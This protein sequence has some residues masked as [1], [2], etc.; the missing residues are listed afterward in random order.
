MW[1]MKIGE[2]VSMKSQQATTKKHLKHF[3]IAGICVADDFCTITTKASMWNIFMR[4]MIYRQPSTTHNSVSR[5][6]LSKSCV[7]VSLCQNKMQLY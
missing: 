3:E 1:M 2:S 7:G 4:S 6:P 5:M